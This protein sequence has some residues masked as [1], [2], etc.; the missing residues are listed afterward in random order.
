[1]VLEWA[2]GLRGVTYRLQN[3]AVRRRYAIGKTTLLSYLNSS[4]LRPI[5]DDSELRVLVVDVGGGID[6]VVV[7]GDGLVD[8][9]VPGKAVVPAGVIG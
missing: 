9:G 8:G 4:Y 5:D 2:S 1:M 6:G 3:G 7:A